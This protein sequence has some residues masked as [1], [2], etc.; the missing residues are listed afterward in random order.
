MR[1]LRACELMSPRTLRFA[2]LILLCSSLAVCTAFGASITVFNTGESSSGTALP[3]GQIDPHYKL[4]SAPSGVPLTAITTTPNPVGT[5]NTATADWMTPMG[6][7]FISEPLGDYDYQ[8]TFSLAGLNPSTAVLSGSWTSD[9]NACIFLN[10]ANT[11]ACTAFEAFG[12]LVPFSITSGF[13]AGVNTLDFVVTNGPGTS[14]NPTGLIAEVRGTA[15]P[16]SV[17]EPCSLLLIGTGLLGCV[18][19]SRFAR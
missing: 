11:R 7:A 6:N 19:R 4:I 12:A 18:A 3:V 2:G 15:S 14:T 8:T 5:P 17:P 9:N 10:G 16:S 13:H 1:G